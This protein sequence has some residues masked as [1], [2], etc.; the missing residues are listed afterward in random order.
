MTDP[1]R[2]V[3]VE[4]LAAQQ[5]RRASGIYQPFIICPSCGEINQREWRYCWRCA[6]AL[7]QGD[8]VKGDA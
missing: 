7:H 8:R 4:P 3:D 2:P 5:A 1:R 6:R